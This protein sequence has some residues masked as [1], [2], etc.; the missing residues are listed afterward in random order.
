MRALLGTLGRRRAALV[1]RSSAER[2]AVV[3][4][5]AGLR[6]SATEPFALGLGAAL[7]L[8]GTAPRLR[9]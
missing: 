9:V 1:E 7:A 3:T 6:R 8:L 4:A 2:A 5:V